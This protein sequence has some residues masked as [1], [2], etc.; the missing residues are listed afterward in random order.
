M[1]DLINWREKNIMQY[2]LKQAR[3]KKMKEKEKKRLSP[4]N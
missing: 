3:R 2:K 1:Q 4:A